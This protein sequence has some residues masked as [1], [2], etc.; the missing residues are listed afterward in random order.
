MSNRSQLIESQKLQLNT[1]EQCRQRVAAVLFNV[2]GGF[3][4]RNGVDDFVNGVCRRPFLCPTRISV[5]DSFIPLSSSVLRLWNDN[6]SF[7]TP[8]CKREMVSAGLLLPL[9]AAG[10]AGS[11][12]AFYCNGF[13][14]RFVYQ[15]DSRQPLAFL[16]RSRRV[17]QRC[18]SGRR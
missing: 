17:A 12:S 6:A 11:S 15:P 3:L 10:T 5:L 7:S 18:E 2:L 13:I 16:H 9:R 4:R 14:G 1:F 8:R